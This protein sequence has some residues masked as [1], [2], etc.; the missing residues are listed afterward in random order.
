MK[1]ERVKG[2]EPSFQA[3][4]APKSDDFQGLIWTHHGCSFLDRTIVLLMCWL[5][6]H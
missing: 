2:I 3:W 1:L 5:T 6:R 4:E